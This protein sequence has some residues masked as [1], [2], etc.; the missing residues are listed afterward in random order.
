MRR[1]AAVLCVSVPLASAISARAQVRCADY[2]AEDIVWCDDYDSYCS[3][4]DPWLGY[5]PFPARCL[6][7]ATQDNGKFTANWPFAPEHAGYPETQWLTKDASYMETSPFN[8][9]FRQ[10]ERD[11]T[12][13][14][15]KEYLASQTSFNLQDAIAAKWTGATAVNG[16]DDDPLILKVYTNYRGSYFREDNLPFYVELALGD[17]RAPVDY[18]EH[19]CAQLAPDYYGP[20]CNCYHQNIDATCNTGDCQVADCNAGTCPLH[21]CWAWSCTIE[22]VCNGGPHV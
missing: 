7:T 19:D 4:A 9:Y 15:L 10:G 11:D 16:S 18:V 17:D 5:P 14:P 6:D 13:P 2:P 12:T 21:E 22:G 3:E 1:L 8:V 20:D